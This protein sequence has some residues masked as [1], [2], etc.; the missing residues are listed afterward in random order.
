MADSPKVSRVQKRGQ[1]TIPIE[2][3]QKMGLEEGDL[4]AFV[5]TP[6][7]VLLSPQAVVPTQTSN[8]AESFRGE[9]KWAN[10]IA[11]QTAGIF[12]RPGQGPID[13]KAARREFMEESVRRTKSKIS[14]EDE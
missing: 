1:V 4:V 9:A 10:S 12:A 8:Q 11:E 14:Q 7:G 6:Q 3:R 13:F 2:I 5:E